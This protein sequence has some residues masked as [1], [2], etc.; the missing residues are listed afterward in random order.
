M[1]FFTNN[2]LFFGVYAGL[3]L[4]M[5]ASFNR[6]H[7]TTSKI[8][9]ILLIF[10]LTV[11]LS[12]FALYR[13]EYLPP[14]FFFISIPF[15]LLT[16]PAFYLYIQNAFFGSRIKV[17]A[18]LHLLPFFISL[19]LLFPF[20]MLD[21]A[22]KIN[23]VD[24]LKD[25]GRLSGHHI[26]YLILGAIQFA[27]YS[28]LVLTTIKRYIK[29]F[30]LVRSDEKLEV[31]KWTTSFLFGV[32]VYLCVYFVAYLALLSDSSLFVVLE[33]VLYI[34]L[35]ILIQ[36]LLLYYIHTGFKTFKQL[37]I[38]KPKYYSSNI[39]GMDFEP[40][41]EKLRKTMEE[42]ELYLDSDLRISKLADVLN[43]P[44]PHV[45]QII[46]EGGNTTFYD[47]VNEYRINK[48][49]E[50][51]KSEKYRNYTLLA[52]AMDAG[53]SNKST[54]NRA[55]KRHTQMTPSQYIKRLNN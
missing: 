29:T 22:S 14:H 4:M 45:S 49:K 5:F 51:L 36:L 6:G 11:R 24:L 21:E 33:L 47:F 48:A 13:T 43:M 40:F 23:Y 16:A 53:F 1:I 18:I 2:F 10:T 54:F 50:L 3:L 15:T 32:I 31:V 7:S 12:E 44:S 34:S 27:T 28:V 20:Y 37:K 55:F 30:V 26:A 38:N 9:F 42:K 25:H 35:C 46:N 17:T 39:Q 19:V 8:L 52:I 41:M